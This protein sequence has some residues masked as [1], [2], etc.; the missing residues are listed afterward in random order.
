M[1]AHIKC[2]VNFIRDKVTAS[3]QIIPELSLVFHLFVAVLLSGWVR[4]FFRF[5]TDESLWGRFKLLSLSYFIIYFSFL[6]RSWYMCAKISSIFKQFSTGYSVSRFFFKAVD[7]GKFCMQLIF[8]QLLTFFWIPHPLEQRPSPSDIF[9][10]LCSR[11]LDLVTRPRLGIRFKS[12]SCREFNIS[13]L[14]VSDSVLCIYRCFSWFVWAVPNLL[15]FLPN[16]FCIFL[17]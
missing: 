7:A 11:W 4:F 17:H 15:T 8:A 9:P 13:M 12:Q 3:L 14:P 5:Y 1:H 2:L 6:E 10:F 16:H